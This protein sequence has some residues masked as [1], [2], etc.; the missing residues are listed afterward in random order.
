MTVP[1]QTCGT[2]FDAKRAAAKFCGDTCRKRAQRT[3]QAP[4]TTGETVTSGLAVVTAS[5]L[6]AAGVTETIAGQQALFIVRAMTG[7][8]Q[9]GAAIAAL[10]KQL[11]AVMVEALQSQQ[12][13]DPLDELRRRR[14]EKRATG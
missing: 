4:L 13:S 5:A 6:A 10:S 7:T 9:T 14:D 1:C 8:A 3:P 2:Q 12:R 11:Q